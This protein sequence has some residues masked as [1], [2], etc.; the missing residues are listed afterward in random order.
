MMVYAVAESVPV[1]LNDCPPGLFLFGGRHLGFKTEYVTTLEDPRRY[2]VDAYVVESGE[3]FHGGAK[4]CEERGKLL[5]QPICIEEEAPTPEQTQRWVVAE[6]FITDET[7]ENDRPVWSCE[8][9]LMGG[10]AVQAVFYG[11]SADEARTF[12]E[13]SRTALAAFKKSEAAHD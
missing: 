11:S 8:L 2:Q 12:A 5:V 10:Y 7:D 13:V 9:Q 3:Y 6:P 1:T 4:G